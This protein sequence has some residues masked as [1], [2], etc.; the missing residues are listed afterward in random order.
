M[1][2]QL[3]PQDTPAEPKPE[4]VRA[5][6]EADAGLEKELDE[7]RP[8]IH[9]KRAPSVDR[10]KVERCEHRVELGA[11]ARTCP[12]C[13]QPERRIGSDASR[14]PEYVPGHFV[15]HEWRLR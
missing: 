1:L 5:D 7:S 2:E 10:R 13:G 6:A 14:V 11:R 9:R 12:R 3:T 4:Q 15:E 8:A